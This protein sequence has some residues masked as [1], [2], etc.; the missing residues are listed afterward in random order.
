MPFALARASHDEMWVAYVETFAEAVKNGDS[1]AWLPHVLNTPIRI[2]ANT[3]L[4]E[5]S[6]Y[7]ESLQQSERTIK[8]GMLAKRTPLLRVA[9]V[10]RVGK[11]LEASHKP[12]TH[13]AIAEFFAQAF[14]HDVGVGVSQFL[15][16]QL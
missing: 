6:I 12:V 8:A 5:L 4:N 13:K 14:W 2:I 3:S 7:L 10:A 11:L 9:E 16:I 15:P 1:D